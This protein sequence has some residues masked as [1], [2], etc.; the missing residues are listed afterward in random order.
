MINIAQ[1]KV[2]SA[3]RQRDLGACWGLSRSHLGVEC[4]MP[5]GWLLWGR[6][7]PVPSTRADQRQNRWFFSRGFTAVP[8]GVL[9]GCCPCVKCPVSVT[10]S[11]LE[12]NG[13][14]AAVG[15]AQ[16]HAAGSS[17]AG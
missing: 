11:G 15:P 5:T 4:C 1:A 14:Q 12:P 16:V 7:F 2:V 17:R 8:P 3:A 9:I 10:L 13:L 6:K